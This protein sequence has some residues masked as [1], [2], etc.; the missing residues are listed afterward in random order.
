MK[1]ENDM[2]DIK[3]V[4][5]MH[6][7]KLNNKVYIGQ[8]HLSNINRRF[9]GGSGY[10]GSSYFYRAIQKYGWENFE[11]II[12]ECNISKID[13][14]EKEKQYI[15][16]QQATNPQFGYNIQEGGR[17][18]TTYINSSCKTKKRIRCKETGIIF[19]SLV[20]A[21]L[22][23][24]YSKEFASNISSQAKGLR[25]YAGKDKDGNPLHWELVD[26][27]ELNGVQ[28]IT[29]IGGSKPVKCLETNEIY[30]SISEAARQ[31]GL[32]SVTITKSCNSQGKIG[33]STLT[34]KEERK[35]THWI[36]V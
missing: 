13:I 4:I 1:G 10:K 34:K 16:K 6:R 2:E 22:Y 7:N 32:S 14:D 25:G 26:D 5:Q 29:K 31:V 20:Q 21:S 17:Y 15:K 28:K 36:W 24:G 19:D 9:R 27:I 12:L 11:H 33:V 8:T 23:Y 30:P 35:Q 18:K 3:Y